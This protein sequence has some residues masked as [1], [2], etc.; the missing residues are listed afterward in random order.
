MDELGF[1]A[2]LQQRSLKE[3]SID[4]YITD[5]RRV[6]AHYGDFDELYKKSGLAEAVQAK[7]PGI[8]ERNRSS[9]GTA[10][11]HY[12][13]FRDSRAAAR[14]S[15]AD[16]DDGGR[17]QLI[18]LERELQ[19]ALRDHIHQLESGL[20]VIDGGFERHVASDFI[21]ITAK[22]P[23]GTVVVIELKAGTAGRDAI[24]QILSYM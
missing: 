3:S 8:S 17:A 24:G 6:E 16:V 22:S 13:D 19:A 4:T 5:A 11:R 10:V 15:V 21:D 23:D 14:D 7:V 2:F 18:G 1:R 20:V 12:R 9:Y